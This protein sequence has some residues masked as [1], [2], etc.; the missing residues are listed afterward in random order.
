MK[1]IKIVSGDPIRVKVIGY[2]STKINE[3]V[4]RNK[5]IFKVTDNVF[6]S[7]FTKDKYRTENDHFVFVLKVQDV[8]VESDIW[9]RRWI[10]DHAD[11]VQLADNAA[12]SYIE[13][14]HTLVKEKKHIPLLRIKLFE[15]LSLDTMPLWDVRHERQILKEQKAQKE[16]TERKAKEAAAKQEEEE[17]LQKVKQQFVNDEYI[18]A[19]DFIT[20][21][22]QDGFDIHIRTKGTL[23]KNVTE[24]NISGT[25]Y[26]CYPKGKKPNLD[27]CHKAIRKYKEFLNK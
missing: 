23:Y 21:C 10:D 3:V 20:L 14:T 4:I 26:I 19:E 17:R 7:E 9:S 5:T 8:Y 24:L 15:Q 11:I 6:L 25:I 2:S 12:L 22:K 16:E 13:N 1:D 27:G 18:S